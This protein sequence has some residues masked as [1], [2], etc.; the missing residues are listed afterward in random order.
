MPI[1][2]VGAEVDIGKAACNELGAQHDINK[3]GRS[4]GNVQV[5]LADRAS[6]EAMNNTVGT[7]DAV[8]S[9]AGDVHF[10]ALLYRRNLHDRPS[11]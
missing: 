8:V 10:G 6:V 11:K 5:D 2:I 1:L 7:V 9:T 3:T 4:S